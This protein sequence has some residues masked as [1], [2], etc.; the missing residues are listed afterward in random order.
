[1]F[2]VK[3]ENRY[4]SK[5]FLVNDD[6]LIIDHSSEIEDFERNFVPRAGMG[7]FLTTEEW[8][9]QVQPSHRTEKAIQSRDAHLNRRLVEVVPIQHV[10]EF[11]RRSDTSW[12][13]SYRCLSGCCATSAENFMRNDMSV[14]LLAHRWLCAF[15]RSIKQIA[16]NGPTELGVGEWHVKSSSVRME[17]LSEANVHLRKSVKMLKYKEP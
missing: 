6:Q 7:R 15:Q 2:F 11:L 1:M 8:K 13:T 5:N 9:C 14:I 10:S 12:N 16:K 17:E 3:R 4:E